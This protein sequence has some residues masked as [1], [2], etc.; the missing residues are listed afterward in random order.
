MFDEHGTGE[1][2]I[3][4]IDGHVADDTDWEQEV[5]HAA[6]LNGMS[7]NYWEGNPVKDMT[8]G[9]LTSG[10]WKW[11]GLAKKQETAR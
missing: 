5:G 11:I 10:V 7:C 8:D 4:V 3:L 6:D 9:T 2:R 1:Q